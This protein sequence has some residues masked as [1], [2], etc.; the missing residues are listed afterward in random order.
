MPIARFNLLLRETIGLDPASVGPA[1][2]ERAVRER[3][4][5]SGAAGLDA[6]WERVRTSE[7]ELQLL[8]E[9]VIV[10][11]T[12][13]FRV[14]PAFDA[15]A[16]L[17]REQSARAPQRPMRLLS[18][19]CSTGEEPY[20]MA[21]AL[22]DAGVPAT[23]FQIDAV[24]ICTRSLAIA[25]RALYGRNSFRGSALDYRARHFTET[26]HGHQLS[27]AVRGQVRFRHG[28]L[29]A[30]G[31]AGGAMPYDFV[32]CRN[33]LIYFDRPTQQR[34]IAV[35]DKLLCEQGIL[36]SGP[37]EAGPLVS[38]E[39][40]SAGISQAFAFRK[41]AA[42]AAPVALKVQ[43]LPCMPAPPQP[44]RHSLAAPYPARAVPAAENVSRA[45]AATALSQAMQLANRGQLAEAAA[46]CRQSIEQAGPS[47]AAFCLMG[48]LSDAGG[49]RAAAGECYRKALYLEPGHH[50]A[51]THLAAL[52]EMQGDAAG[53]RRIGERARRAQ[54]RQPS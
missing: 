42:V 30:P 15:L 47:A 38:Q 4:A 8:I 14:V 21:M 13:F 34:A 11:E 39:M 17:A 50:E 48:V 54:A 43:P 51:L 18:L 46:L 5:A 20:S 7:S 32:F 27:D 37:A 22:L 16:R 44:A 53:A 45:P 35:L 29:F 12:W 25:E 40:V 28:N 31:L 9:T 33:L 36:F 49:D 19:P 6:Y 26:P 10:P 3:M 1:A 23:H 24:D 52:L 41:P 2:V